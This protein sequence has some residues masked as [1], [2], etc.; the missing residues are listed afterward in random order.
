MSNI[1]EDK[2]VKEYVM[3]SKKDENHELESKKFEIFEI[4]P[5]VDKLK[6]FREEYIKMLK[7]PKTVKIVSNKPNW[8]YYNKG[9]YIHRKG[10]FEFGIVPIEEDHQSLIKQFIQYGPTKSQVKALRYNNDNIYIYTPSTIDKCGRTYRVAPAIVINEDIYNLVKIQ[11][12]DFESICLKDLSSYKPFF[13]VS[14]EPYSVVSENRIEDL[15]RIG[16]LS[17]QEYLDSLNKYEHEARLVKTL[18]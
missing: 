9:I 8:F 2:D 14:E 4:I 10:F 1:K 7:T 16:E 17:H 12:R 3:C 5:N 11:N 18:K 15:Y 13:K 6:L